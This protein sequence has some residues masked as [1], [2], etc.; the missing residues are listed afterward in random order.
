MQRKANSVT[1]RFGTSSQEASD[2]EQIQITF[3]FFDSNECTA[4]VDSVKLL[5]GIYVEEYGVTREEKAET[6]K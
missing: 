3:N 5:F 2:G 6:K 4:F 1:C